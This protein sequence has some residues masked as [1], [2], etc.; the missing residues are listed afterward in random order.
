[1]ELKATAQ[2]TRKNT[3]R[4]VLRYSFRKGRLVVASTKF[5]HWRP[6]RGKMTGGVALLSATVFRLVRIIHTKGKIMMTAPKMRNT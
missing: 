4:A 5:F 1:M 2:I 6:S 3:I